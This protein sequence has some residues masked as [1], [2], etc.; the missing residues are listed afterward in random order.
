MNRQKEE[1]I[2]L[3]GKLVFHNTI[4]LKF[5]KKL[6]TGNYRKTAVIKIRGWGQD[7]LLIIT[8]IL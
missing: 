8:K 4:V 7:G 3:P 1:Q 6:L 5:I 2:N